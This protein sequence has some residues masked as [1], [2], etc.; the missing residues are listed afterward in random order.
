MM[1]NKILVSRLA[2]NEVADPNTIRVEIA[3]ELD[4]TDTR[5][6]Q[7]LGEVLKAL[8]P[9][10]ERPDFVEQFKA[11]AAKAGVPPA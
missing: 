9:E 4:S 2:E 11:A 8:I 10:P 7:R 3:V 6:M 1:K 5:A